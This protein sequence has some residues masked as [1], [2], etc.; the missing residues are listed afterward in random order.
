MKTIETE[1]LILRGWQLNDLDDLFEYA[2]NPNVGP[3]SGWEPHAN[4]EV[5]LNVLKHYLA[6]DD[7]WAIS[8]KENG[9]V[10][11][12]IKLRPDE[13]R[14]NYKAKYISFALSFDYWGKGYMTEA[15]KGVV[16][17]VFDEM[18]IDLLS[19]FHFPHNIRSKRVL[20]KCGFTYEVTI[21]HGNTIYDGQIFD[22]VC[23]SLLKTDYYKSMKE[24]QIIEITP[25][26]LSKCVSFWGDGNDSRLIE[27]N[28]FVYKR[29]SEYVGGFALFE[30]YEKCGH[31]SHFFVKSDLRGQ[32][33][34]SSLLEFAIEHL[35]KTGMEV[36]RLHVD[37]D[38]LR[39]IKLYEKYGFVYSGDA[40][41]DKMIMLKELN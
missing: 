36:M 11:G 35:K 7:R 20:E 6:N 39:A 9:K 16:K 1:R 5:S 15:V 2:K 26:E 33:I 17:Y 37:K 12:S 41:P 29:G 25:D 18:E 8:L 19:A 23:Y 34:G 21:K 4:K 27:R 24:Y 3:M 31:F 22:T 13:N 30:R 40:S 28:T 14:G 38:N 32:G 10:I